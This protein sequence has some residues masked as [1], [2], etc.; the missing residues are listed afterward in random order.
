M[1][2][3]LGP[4]SAILLLASHVPANAQDAPCPDDDQPPKLGA[5]ASE[6]AVCSRIG[7]DLLQSGG[8]AV[9]SI[10][11]AVFCVGTVAMYHS[12][13]A[14]GGFMLVRSSDGTYETVNFREAA[15]A[16]AHRDMYEGNFDGSLNGGLARYVELSATLPPTLFTQ[17]QDEGTS[18]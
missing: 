14:G 16:A 10:V 8:N 5:V 7:T 15:P 12:G 13:P 9:D 11:G 17:P 3:L 2:I 4:V 6:S 1:R 18:R